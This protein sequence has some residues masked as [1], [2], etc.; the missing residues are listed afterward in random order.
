MTLKRIVI[1]YQA[2][3]NIRYKLTR[4]YHYSATGI[5]TDA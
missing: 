2:V 5:K 4:G 1:V 3:R